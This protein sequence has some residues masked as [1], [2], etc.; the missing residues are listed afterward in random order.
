MILTT[1]RMAIW[2]IKIE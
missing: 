1:K 2:V